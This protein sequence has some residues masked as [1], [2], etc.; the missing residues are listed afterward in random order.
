MNKKFI[1]R[2]QN[3]GYVYVDSNAGDDVIGDG[4]MQN[5]YQTLGR[6]YR[7]RGTKPNTICCRGVF[8]EDMADGNHGCTIMGDYAGAAVFDGVDKYTFYGFTYTNFIIKNCINGLPNSTV[9]S[10]NPLYAGVGRA[11]VSV[12]VGVTSAGYLLGL[13]G[14]RVIVRGCGPYF[15]IVGG[16]GSQNVIDSP[17]WNSENQLFPFGYNK[18]SNWTIYNVPKA[19]RRVSRNCTSRASS[20][21]N[22]S[23]FGKFCFYINDGLTFYGCYFT[24]D[25]EWWNADGTEKVEIV[26]DSSEERIQCLKTYMEEHLAGTGNNAAT[27]ACIFDN[28]VFLD[29]TSEEVFNDCQF[30]D[31]SVKLDAGIPDN[32]GFY[33]NCLSIGVRDFLSDPAG[34]DERAMWDWS[35]VTEL[36]DGN[37]L[38]KFDNGSMKLDIP[39]DTEWDSAEICSTVI[40]IDPINYTIDTAWVESASQFNIKALMQNKNVVGSNKYNAGDDLPVGKYIVNGRIRYNGSV[41]FDRD[42]VTILEGAPNQF[43]TPDDWYEECTVTELDDPNMDAVFYLRTFPNLVDVLENVTELEAGKIY[44]VLE[45]P[46]T[47]MTIPSDTTKNRKLYKGSIVDLEHETT[48]VSLQNFGAGSKIGVLNPI[49]SEW[50]PQQLFGELFTSKTGASIDH[51]AE[52]LA[53]GSGNPNTWM[54]K[55][56]DNPNGTMNTVKKQRIIHRYSQ[57]KIV[58]KPC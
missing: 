5:P 13:S 11:N 43:E 58:V 15:G 14:S 26:G 40:E 35:T 34:T 39:E 54:N 48:N 33:G 1:W 32:V 56:A 7:G 6:A 38:I 44:V 19:G 50:V 42:V 10:G 55:T 22:F 57:L 18:P 20:G 12:T 30:G 4:T 28:C 47:I 31:L 29:K 25:C 21:F 3:A 49:Y 17:R 24:S 45:A 16:S 52:G 46:N 51:D 53:L 8:S 27:T 2:T 23:L 9:F 37:K 36:Q 41:Y